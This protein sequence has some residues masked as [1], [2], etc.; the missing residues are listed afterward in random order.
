MPRW[1]ARP[2]RSATLSLTFDRRINIF[3]HQWASTFTIFSDIHHTAISANE[4]DV[5]RI[6]MPRSV[7]HS[8]LPAHPFPKPRSSRETQ[9]ACSI[10]SPHANVSFKRFTS[11]PT[12]VKSYVWST[13]VERPPNFILSYYFS[14]S[15]RLSRHDASRYSAVAAI[16][17]EYLSIS[18]L[19]STTLSV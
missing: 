19:V 1:A 10:K 17:F 16:I 3:R 11:L 12:E 18:L 4:Y 6:F 5:W 13:T 14:F 7:A 9:S 8:H 15:S 2:A